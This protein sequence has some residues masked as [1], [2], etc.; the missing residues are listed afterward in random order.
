MRHGRC[1]SGRSRSRSQSPRIPA[2]ALAGLRAGSAVDYWIRV[3]STVGLG[4]PSFLIATLLIYAV[5]LKLGLLPTNGWSESW[6]HKLLPAFSLSLL[7]MGYCARLVRGSVLEVPGQDYLRT[8]AAKGL[9]GRRSPSGTC[10]GIRSCPWSL[11]AGRCS[12]SSSR[13]RS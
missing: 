6:H 9:A 8:A 2:G 7:P 1:C 13:A 12:A 3:A 4:L 10:F 11:P 5:A